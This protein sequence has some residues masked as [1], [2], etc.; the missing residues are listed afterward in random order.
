[1]G[2]W[3]NPG[4]HCGAGATPGLGSV[5]STPELGLSTRSVHTLLA[6]S[7]TGRQDTP[8]CPRDRGSLLQGTSGWPLAVVVRPAGHSTGCPM[9]QNT[10]AHLLST[11]FLVASILGST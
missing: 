2:G 10:G 9:K 7:T 4:H 1:M 6:L 3:S 11:R 8:R 5:T